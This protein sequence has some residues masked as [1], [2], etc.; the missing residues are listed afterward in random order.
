MK[1]MKEEIPKSCIGM[2]GFFRV[3]I[4]DQETGEIVGD[5]GLKH[6]LIT[7]AGITQYITYLM[8]ASAGSLVVGYGAL[9][10][11]TGVAAT[12]TIL[13]GSFATSLH[14]TV[15][16]TFITRGGTASTDFES[17]RYLASWSSGT[18]T[19]TIAN[20]GLYG[21]QTGTIM[22]AGTF[23]SSSVASNQAINLTYDICFA[24]Y[25]S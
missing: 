3:N 5:S 14:R 20:V 11:G 15:T 12:S 8:C 2:H 9:G 4:V 19:A 6:N 17:V 13:P 22:C 24:A 21:T 1:E 7:S 10:S 18:S 23:A 16:R 25:T